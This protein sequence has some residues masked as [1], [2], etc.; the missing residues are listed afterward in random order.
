MGFGSARA[1]EDFRASGSRMEEKAESRY[2]A[3]KT[4]GLRNPA[5]LFAPI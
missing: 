4:E 3:S 1:T 5:Q 2:A